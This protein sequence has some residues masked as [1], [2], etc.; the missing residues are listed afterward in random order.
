M[1]V[2]IYYE[3]GARK[4]ANPQKPWLYKGELV[5]DVEI[6]DEER[7]EL[8]IPRMLVGIRIPLKAFANSPELVKKLEFMTTIY[9]GLDI[10]T[11][12]WIT[13]VENVDID[14]IPE[15]ISFEEYK[16]FKALEVEFP[17]GIEE[18]YPEAKKDEKPTV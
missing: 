15:F 4:R 8:R 13:Y 14:D 12:G 16:K 9:S 10:H 1:Q 7:K 17:E 3:N 18:L 11:T 2:K 6:T 5:Y